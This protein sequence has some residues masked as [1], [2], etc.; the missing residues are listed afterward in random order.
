MTNFEYIMADETR[1]KKF[2]IEGVAFEG[3]CIKTCEE[4]I[5]CNDCASMS[6]F[7]GCEN[8]R[9]NFLEQEYI[10]PCRF[11]MGDL[12]LVNGEIMF[13]NGK[14]KDVNYYAVTR[15]IERIGKKDKYDKPIGAEVY[16]E[17]VKL[18]KKD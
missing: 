1:A 14:L 3:D 17:D 5:N 6:N 10:E 7:N 16:K 11:K 2:L 13:F 9:R 18:Y 8:W 15:Y 12:V 4:V